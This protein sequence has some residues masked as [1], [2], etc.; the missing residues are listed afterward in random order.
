[1]KKENSKGSL[2]E[3]ATGTFFAKYPLLTRTNIAFEKS[4]EKYHVNV[5][6]KMPVL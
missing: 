4:E 3:V 1:M 5:M 6:Y 2:N